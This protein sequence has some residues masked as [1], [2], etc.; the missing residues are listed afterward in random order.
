MCGAEDFWPVARF[1][2]VVVCGECGLSY[3]LTDTKRPVAEIKY[4]KAN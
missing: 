4:G 1:T 3:C 2:D